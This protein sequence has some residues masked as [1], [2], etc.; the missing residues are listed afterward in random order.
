MEEEQKI[1][2]TLDEA[3]EI[4]IEYDSKDPGFGFNG[5]GLRNGWGLWQGSKLAQ[6]F[7]KRQIY[8]ADD[9]S[10]IIMDTYKRTKAGDDIKLTEQISKYHNH[11]KK[12]FGDMHLSIMKGHV[13]EHLT[14]MRAENLEEI[15]R[16]IEV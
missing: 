11:W 5:M 9:M 12:Q 8:H 2:T 3:V 4:L 1:P 10:G 15:L 14:N 7:F 13:V 16:D 6:W